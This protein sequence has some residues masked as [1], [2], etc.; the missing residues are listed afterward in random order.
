M[1]LIDSL[2][3]SLQSS[4]QSSKILPG[5]HA[6]TSLRHKTVLGRMPQI[7]EHLLADVDCLLDTVKDALWAGQVGKLLGNCVGLVDKVGLVG[8]GGVPHKGEAVC[9]DIC[10]VLVP[11]QQQAS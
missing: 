9:H 3:S 1:I 6:S 10:A 8:A 4:Y 5:H 2:T 11:A 7:T